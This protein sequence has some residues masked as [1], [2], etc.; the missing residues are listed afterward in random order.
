M[1]DSCSYFFINLNLL[2]NNLKIRKKLPYGQGCAI[3]LQSDNN[4]IIKL[5]VHEYLKNGKTGTVQYSICAEFNSECE[6][7]EV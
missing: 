2:S 4:I 5:K 3:T 1:G 7:S 6:Y